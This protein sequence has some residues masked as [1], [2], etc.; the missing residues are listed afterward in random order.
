MQPFWSVIL[1]GGAIAQTLAAWTRIA[2]PDCCSRQHG[3]SR[4]I[5]FAACSSSGTVPCLEIGATDLFH[6]AGIFFRYPPN[7]AEAHDNAF[8][9]GGTVDIDITIARINAILETDQTPRD[10][11][12]Q[13]RLPLLLRRAM[14]VSSRVICR[15]KWLDAFR[16]R[17]TH[18]S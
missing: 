10:G 16:A 8:E 17:N 6:K 1:T 14:T 7:Y 3:A 11:S 5:I 15:T 18:R 2:F 13:C 12:D 4:A 9:N